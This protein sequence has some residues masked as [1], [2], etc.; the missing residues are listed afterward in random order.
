MNYRIFFAFILILFLIPVYSDIEYRYNG[1]LSCSISNSNLNG[2]LFK[3]YY[4]D[5]SHVSLCSSSPAPYYVCQINVQSYTI[6]INF[7]WTNCQGPFLYLYEATNSHVSRY[8]TSYLKY[9]ICFGRYFSEVLNV[10]NVS[11]PG[12]FFLIGLYNENNSHVTTNESKSIIRLY[13]NITDREYPN[14][15]YNNTNNYIKLPTMISVNFSDNKYLYF[16]NININGNP[17]DLSSD[18]RYKSFYNYS[19]T[20]TKSDCP[21]K[22]CTI[23]YNAIDLAGNMYGITKTYNVL[24][25]CLELTVGS[26]LSSIILI[27]FDPYYLRIILKNPSYCYGNFTNVILNL[28]GKNCEGIILIDGGTSFTYNVSGDLPNGKLVNGGSWDTAVRIDPLRTGNCILY[29]N[30][31]ATVEGL[32]ENVIYSREI[33]VSVSIRTSLGFLIVSEPTFIYIIIL[34][35]SLILFL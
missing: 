17:V 5:N 34:V 16:C 7:S 15:F 20:I 29:V 21:D 11:T 6:P 24:E 18:C 28:N 4:P 30:V 3:I 13:L 9:S 32:N 26:G 2:C 31:N 19:F 22:S 1:T 35:I 14:I 27:G 10:S 33:P 25:P 23:T 12:S 8:N